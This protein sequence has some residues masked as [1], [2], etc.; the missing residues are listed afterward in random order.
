M[1]TF[2]TIPYSDGQKHIG[3]YFNGMLLDCKGPYKHEE[4]E[5]AKREF[6]IE[7][8]NEKQLV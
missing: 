1:I 7:F 6:E 2:Q 5:E 3:V 8:N 4:V